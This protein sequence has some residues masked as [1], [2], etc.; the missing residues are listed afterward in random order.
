MKPAPA[1][2]LFNLAA[3]SGMTYF[4]MSSAFV[5]A[6]IKAGIHPNQTLDLSRIRAAGATG[7]PLTVEGFNWVYDNIN[8]TLAL[9]SLSGGTDLCTP[10]VGG[11]RMQPIYAGEIQGAWLGAKVQ[12]FNE[13]GQPIMDEIGELVITEP[14]PSMPLYFWND[15][16]MKRYRDSYFDVFPNIWRHGDWISSTRAAAASSTGVR[17]RPSTGRGIRMGTSEIYRVVELLDVVTDSLIIDLELLGR[18]SRLILFVVLQAG[19]VL[20][21][22]VE[23]A[24]KQQVRRELSPRHVPDDVVQINAVPYTLSGKKDLK[25]RFVKSCWGWMWIPRPIGVRCVTPK[26]WIFS[27]ITANSFRILSMIGD[28]RP[29]AYVAMMLSGLE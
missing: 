13:A 8:S 6:C 25:C 23:Q 1:N 10:F 28:I 2:V 17:T 18:E 24:I 11:V 7:S 22:T 5:S 26:R 27:S 14:M 19:Q 4:G 15:P 3:Q 16:E 21:N 12:A 9:E 20:D 29:Y